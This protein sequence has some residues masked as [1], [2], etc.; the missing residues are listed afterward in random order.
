G[1]GGRHDDGVFQGAVL[2]ELAHH[3]VDRGR[4]LADGDVHAGDA[5]ALLVDA[6][7]DGHGRLAGLA[8]ADDQL[9]L[10]APDGDHGVDG[11]L[12]GLQRLRHGLA[13]D[14]ARRD[15]FDHVGFLGIDRALAVDRVAQGIDHAAAQFGADRHGQDAAGGLDGVAFGDTDVV[16]QHHGAHGVALEVQGQAEL[17]VGEFEHFA[18]HHVG[19]AVDA[20]D[21]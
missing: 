12:A 5:L 8:V 9:T 11:L 15:L 16:A 20:G 18:L 2:F 4:L 3:V 21:A 7:V 17:V 14:H 6:G 13:G 1:R 10:A 19:Q